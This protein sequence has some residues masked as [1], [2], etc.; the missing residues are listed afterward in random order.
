MTLQVQLCFK[1]LTGPSLV[2]MTLSDTFINNV[3][4]GETACDLHFPSPTTFPVL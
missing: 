3:G 1:P 4:E 2:I